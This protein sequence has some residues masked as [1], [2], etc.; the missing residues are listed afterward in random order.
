MIQEKYNDINKEIEKLNQDVNNL[1]DKN[2]I[3]VLKNILNL[4]ED[5]I[6]YIN[7]RE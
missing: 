6:V 5:I 4:I 2:Y 7:L 1:D 3:I